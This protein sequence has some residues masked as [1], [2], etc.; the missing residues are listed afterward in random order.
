MRR[1]IING[2]AHVML[3]PDPNGRNLPHRPGPHQ[4]GIRA[5]A[6]PRRNQGQLLLAPQN[7]PHRLEKKED[8][9]EVL[10]RI[11]AS[12]A[13]DL[14]IFAGDI[15]HRTEDVSK[16]LRD[17]QLPCPK[18]WTLGNHD[19]WVIDAESESDTAEYRYRSL[20][21][22]I[23]EKWNWHYLPMKPLSMESHQVDVIGTMGWFTGEGYSEWF[24]GD[25]TEKDEELARAFANDL[26]TAFQN[27][28]F[29]KVIVVTHHVPNHQLMNP[30]KVNRAEVNEHIPKL[31]PKYR[32][33]IELV[34]HGHR[35]K[36]YNLKT[37][38]G[39]DC[40]VHPFGYPHQHATVENGF[41]VIEI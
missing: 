19:I 29:K 15:S 37:I 10:E 20:F 40:V 23:S 21:P 28:R 12:D 31:L 5:Y 39:I 2:E 27:T 17:I 25:A 38:D 9:L 8:V 6:I 33:R 13:L 32:D 16:F 1:P 24:D 30:T 18:C 4:P 35:H 22:R 36:R 26:E 34:I 14:F 7:R 11:N 41:R 3:R